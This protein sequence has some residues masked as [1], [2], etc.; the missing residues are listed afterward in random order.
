MIS[1]F[2]DRDMVMRYHWG[3]GVGHVYAHNRRVEIGIPRDRDIERDEQ[4][5]NQGEDDHYSLSD[6]SETGEISEAEEVRGLDLCDEQSDIDSESAESTD[7]NAEDDV[8]D[9]EN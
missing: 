8:L 3:L 1:R 9:Y 4:A 2:V 7:E 6:S 5:N